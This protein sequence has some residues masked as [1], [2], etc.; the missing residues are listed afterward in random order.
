MNNNRRNK[1]IL[2][3]F[4]F[5]LINTMYGCKKQTEEIKKIEINNGAI[6]IEN[7]GNYKI[8]N[9]NNGEYENLETDNIITSYD[10]ES[11]NYIFSE[12]GEFK[13]DYL[14]E[15]T[16]IDESNTILSPKLSPGGHYLSYFVKDIYLDLKIKDLKLDELINIDSK[17]AISGELIDWYSEDTLIYYGIDDEKNNGLFIYNISNNEEKLI[18]K[19]DSGYIEYLKVLDNGV[20]F[21]QEKEGKDKI[22][23]F[24]NK[25][26][27]LS[28]IIEN[29]VDL[30]DV[31]Y[32]QDK[33]YIIGRMENN[34][35]SLYEYNE[36]KIKRL[37]YD[38]PKI[39]N[40]E[41]GLSKDSD[42]NILFIGG[43]EPNTERVYICTD[44]AI[45][46]LSDNEGK[47]YFINY[48]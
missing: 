11:K 9:L 37:V 39:I 30:S 17:V 34:N 36:G 45:S 2:L 5:L 12:D 31:E 35:Y 21:L 41:K 18:Y 33:M 15:R 23:K 8:Y 25:D 47:Y 42:G 13:I 20:V 6:A 43:D 24:I 40:L 22:L 19:L 10:S 7:N 3:S 27:E 26:G 29:V 48:H 32:T 44:G 1:V 28:E 4:I 14:G 46:R 38:F 16:V